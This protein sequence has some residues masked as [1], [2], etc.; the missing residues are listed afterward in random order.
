MHEDRSCSPDSNDMHN[1][2]CPK[3]ALRTKW[4]SGDEIIVSM[5]KLR[6]IYCPCTYGLNVIESELNGLRAHKVPLCD[7]P[8]FTLQVFARARASAVSIA[9]AVVLIVNGIE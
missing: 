4:F 3:M 6:K 5:R 2:I 1:S 8:H 9:V 7:D